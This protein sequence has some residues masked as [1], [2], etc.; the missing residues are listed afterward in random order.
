MKAIGCKTAYNKLG[1]RN[2][3]FNIYSYNLSAFKWHETAL[4]SREEVN[5]KVSSGVKA[6]IASG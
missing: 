4:L 5:L 2:P 3:E 6:N 1:T